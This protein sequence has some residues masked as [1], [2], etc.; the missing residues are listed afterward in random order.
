MPRYYCTYFDKNYIVKGLTLINSLIKHESEPFC[1]YV[2]CLD[3]FT[4]TTLK[5]LNIKEIITIPVEAIEAGD[6][7]LSVAKANRHLVEYYWTLTPTIIFRI[8]QKLPSDEVLTYLDA[9]LFFFSTPQPIFDELGE[10]AVLIHEHRFA[11]PLK[12]LEIYGKYNVGLLVFRAEPEGFAVLNRWRQQ[13][14]EWCYDKVEDGK[15]ADQRYLDDW[16]QQFPRV[17]VLKHIGAGVAP[18]NNVQYKISNRTSGMPPLINDSP[19]I[20]YHFHA[21]EFFCPELMIVSRHSSYLFSES[22]VRYCYYPYLLAIHDVISQIREILPGFSEGLN[23]DN[24]MQPWMTFIA[25][26]AS[27]EIIRNAGI[28]NRIMP[29]DNT[30]GC[31]CSDQVVTKTRTDDHSAQYAAAKRRLER[32]AHIQAAKDKIS[33]AVNFGESI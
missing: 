9:D 18:W 19:L 20:F 31:Y 10:S 13:C 29:L 33:A 15:Y 24:L 3:T 14:N 5:A 11:D 1:M 16:P 21:L 7:N 6:Y 17:H 23:R 32:I 30:W 4:Q 22:V 27:A 2:V 8:L 12:Y 25:Q 28:N 26:R